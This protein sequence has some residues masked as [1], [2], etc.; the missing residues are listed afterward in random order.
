VQESGTR[1]TI[2]A[3][4]GAA[5][6]NN[7]IALVDASG[8]MGNIGTTNPVV[9]NLVNAGANFMFRGISFTPSQGVLLPVQLTS[10]S[11]SVINGDAKLNWQVTNEINVQKYIV[12]QS[13]D[14]VQFRAVGTVLAKNLSQPFTYSY[15]HGN[16]AAGKNYYRLKM[17]DKDG[18]FSY[19]KTILLHVGK[20]GTQQL[21]IAPNPVVN[22]ITITHAKATKNARLMVVSITGNI[23]Q[24]IYTS[25]QATQTSFD[26]S[27]LV[28]GTYLIKYVNNGTVETKSFI[29]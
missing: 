2:Y 22:S 23:V 28:S 20:T 18:S 19:S 6:N 17:V 27:A 13:T 3:V 16:I 4:K 14:A 11:G 26:V 15:I 10:F 29:K 8:Y 21:V 1:A 24:E 9:T 12:E 5:S 25:E 7:I